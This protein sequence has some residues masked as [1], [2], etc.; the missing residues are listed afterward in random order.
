MTGYPDNNP[1]T[2]IGAAKVPLHLVPPC[3]SHYLAEAFADGARK[4]GPYNWRE[5]EVS[6][7]VYYSAMK[8]HQDAWWDGEDVSRDALVHH[9]GHVM[10][11]AAIILD[12][13]S[14]GKLNDDR[15]LPGATPA[16]QAGYGLTP[17]QALDMV[18]MDVPQPF[19]VEPVLVEEV[20]DP[21]LSQQL[22]LGD[23]EAATDHLLA[24]KATPPA[25]DG[26]PL[27][28]MAGEATFNA[29]LNPPA[30]NTGD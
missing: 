16:L 12:A 29:P 10:A 17:A 27:S 22:A 28:H 2:A 20:A 6:A 14:V 24:G 26:H 25:Y 9:L 1:K 18:S 23:E 5:H 7:S 13:M 19:P 30:A 4:Y 3:A 8:R 21:K 15:P 11:C